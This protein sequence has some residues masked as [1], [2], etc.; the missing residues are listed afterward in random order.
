[1]VNAGLRR[2][3]AVVL[4]ATLAVLVSLAAL[5]G[6]AT[7]VESAHGSGSQPAVV[8]AVQAPQAA[9]HLDNIAL[10]AES[11]AEPFADSWLAGPPSAVARPR[12]GVARAPTGRSPPFS[13]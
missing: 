11:Q 8:L 6:V 12:P 4:V 13:H 2:A 9:A 7:G 3:L 5:A 1:M 10:P